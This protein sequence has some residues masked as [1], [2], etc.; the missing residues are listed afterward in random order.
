MPGAPP[1]AVTAMTWTTALG[2][3][4]YAVWERMLPGQAGVLPHEVRGPPAQRAGGRGPRDTGRFARDRAHDEDGAPGAAPRPRRGRAR[5]RRP[6]PAARPRYEPGRLPRGRCASVAR[7]G[8]RSRPRRGRRGAADL[9]LDG[10]LVRLRRDRRGG[11]ADPGGGRAMLRLRRRRRDHHEQAPR[12][13]RAG[14]H[15]PD[16]PARVRRAARRDPD[17]RGR[18]VSSSSTPSPGARARPSPGCAAPARPT[19]RAA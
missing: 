6:R 19:T 4:L 14:D 1:I 2:D 5:R 18:R 9:R 16:P 11:R 7:V 12:T 17:R 10:V 15:V 3:D 13:L 8:R